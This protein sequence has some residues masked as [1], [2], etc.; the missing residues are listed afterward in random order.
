VSARAHWETDHNCRYRAIGAGGAITGLRAD[1]VILDDPVRSPQAAESPF[2]R[3]H[4]WDWFN[5]DLMTR[6]KPSGAIV[7]ITTS[8][9]EDDLAS[10]LLR[11][12]GAAAWRV[13]RLPAI[14]EQG[15]P[16][17]RVE[18]K[19]LWSDHPA[20]GARLLALREMVADQ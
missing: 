17:G 18:G 8:Y 7:L 5:S 15:D 20:D 1:L 13:L 9:H 2:T 4:L 19:P 6:L 12:E 11:G 3:T 14:A 16:L 10:R